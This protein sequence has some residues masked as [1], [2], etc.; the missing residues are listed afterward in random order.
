M[1]PEKLP[2]QNLP[3]KYLRIIQKDQNIIFAELKWLSCKFKFKEE[4]F[5]SE[6]NSLKI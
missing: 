2:G 6:L 1:L 3:E 4:M 5:L